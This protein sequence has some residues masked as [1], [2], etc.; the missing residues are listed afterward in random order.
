MTSHMLGGKGMW[1]TLM[2]Q[3]TWQWI[4][5]RAEATQATRRRTILGILGDGICQVIGGNEG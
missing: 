2:F 5:N 1:L 4:E 3:S